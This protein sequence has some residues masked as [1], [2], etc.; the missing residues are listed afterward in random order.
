MNNIE[1]VFPTKEHEADA[2]EFREEHFLNG[3]KSING[4][5]GLDCAENYDKWL[6]KIN[7]EL[8]HTIFSIIFFAIRKSDMKIVG[9]INIRYPYLDY[10]QIHGHIGYS[11]RPSE[12]RKGYGTEMLKLALEYCRT[13][14]LNNV[15]LT[16]DKSNIAS[17]KTIMKCSGNLES[18]ATQPDGEILQRYWIRF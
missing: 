10:V 18:E 4:D 7:N 8:N 1:L 13:A 3:E 12:R 9:T 17:A 2:L 5:C 15:L 16:C 14:G 11:I 6:E